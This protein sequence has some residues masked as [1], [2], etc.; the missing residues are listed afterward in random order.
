M[1]RRTKIAPT[2]WR[3]PNQLTPYETRICEYLTQ[4]MS[5]RQVTDALGGGRSIDSVRT[6]INQ[7]CIL[8][9][10]LGI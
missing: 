8:K 10:I 9:Q 2:Q 5:L 7:S 6:T 4:G 1:D 3:D